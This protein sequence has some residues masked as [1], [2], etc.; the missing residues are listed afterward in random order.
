MEI[1]KILRTSRRVTYQGLMD[2][3]GVS[4]QTIWRDVIV[5]SA[6][7]PIQTVTG[8]AGGIEI[9]EDLSKMTNNQLTVRDEHVVIEVLGYAKEE[10]RESLKHILTSFGDYGKVEEYRNL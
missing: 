4:K 10:H 5:L 7:F 2:E 9:T 6:H 8:P 3:F 1:I